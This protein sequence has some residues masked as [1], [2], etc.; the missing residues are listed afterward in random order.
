MVTL[1]KFTLEDQPPARLREEDKILEA[2]RGIRAHNTS[3]KILFYQ[4]AWQD[5]PQYSLHNL[6]AGHLDDHW[7]VQGDDGQFVCATPPCYY[8]HSNAQMRAA[9]VG[10]LVSVLSTGLVDGFFIDITPQALPDTD[11]VSYHGNIQSICPQPNCSAARQASLLDGLRLA[12]EELEAATPPGTIIICNPADFSSCN[13]EFF[14]YFG[15]SADHGRSVAGD[16]R[17]LRDKFQS[18]GHLIQARAAGTN[19]ST[20]FH[21]GEFLIGANEQTYF[22]QS[23]SPG[24][25]CTDGW[26]EDG[27]P[28]DPDFFS[29]PL[30]APLG[31]FTNTSNGA[32]AGAAAAGFVYTRSFAKGTHVWLNLTSGWKHAR[33]CTRP[34]KPWPAMPEC[35]QLCIWWG[36]G[37]TSAFPPGFQCAK[38]APFGAGYM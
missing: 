33:Q 38:E 34:G 13:V 36:D 1:E 22:G 26:L 25:G 29:H 21:V 14:E 30:G 28:G 32:G 11:N 4:M 10:N 8:N 37:A 9:W 2:A 24:W 16:F 19:D 23:R 6:T 15:S 31:D 12:F 5:F 7:S 20:A 3:A 17:R 35:P 18:T 27:V